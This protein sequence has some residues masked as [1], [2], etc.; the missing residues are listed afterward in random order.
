MDLALHGSRALITG[1]SRGIGLAIVGALAAEGATVGLIAGETG[2]LAAAARLLT[3]VTCP[4]A[5]ASADVTDTD[6][7]YRAVEDIAAGAR[8]PGPSGRQRGR[9]RR[10]RQ[11]RQRRPR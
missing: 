7:L 8:R 5:T 3:A 10:Q 9:H 4:V 6:A 11:P 1:G 2:G